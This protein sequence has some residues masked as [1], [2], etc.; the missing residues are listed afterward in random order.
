VRHLASRVVLAL[1]LSAPL[2]GCGILIGVGVAA[3]SFALGRWISRQMKVLVVNPSP[4]VPI[5]KLLFRMAPDDEPIEIDVFVEPGP[6]PKPIT[7]DW[8]GPAGWYDVLAV[9][10]DGTT[11]YL[12]RILLDPDGPP[13]TLVFQPPIRR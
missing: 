3:G 10:A 6:E 13:A 7:I 4:D 1:A 2:C 8:E 12:T 5:T 9:Y 11:A